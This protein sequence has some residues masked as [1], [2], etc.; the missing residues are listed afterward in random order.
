MRESKY[1]VLIVYDSRTMR[2]MLRKA[3]EGVTSTCQDASSITLD[4]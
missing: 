4:K 2:I 1:N 3:I